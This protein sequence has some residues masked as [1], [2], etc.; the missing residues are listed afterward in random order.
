MGR[1]DRTSDRARMRT[2]FNMCELP[3]PVSVTHWSTEIVTSWCVSIQLII[4]TGPGLSGDSFSIPWFGR[5]LAE[6]ERKS[7]SPVAS[8]GSVLFHVRS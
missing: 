8:D 1:W 3:S 2:P 4:G 7:A 5:A 6:I